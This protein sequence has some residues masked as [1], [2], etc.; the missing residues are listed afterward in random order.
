MLAWLFRSSQERVSATR[1]NSCGSAERVP[2][3]DPK[4]NTLD[5]FGDWGFAQSTT[6][7]LHF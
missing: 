6:V 5:S 1:R 4:I 7:S 2:S 3:D